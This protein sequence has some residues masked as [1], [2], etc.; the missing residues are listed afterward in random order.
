M[1]RLFRDVRKYNTPQTATLQNGLKVRVT[2]VSSVRHILLWR[3][4]DTPPSPREAHA[5]GKH[6]GFGAFYVKR[7]KT[8][9]HGEWLE[10]IE[11]QQPF[12]GG[13]A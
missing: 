9:A 11:N 3:T 13:P 2:I 7:G 5:I 4:P 1:R 8:T 6:A 10:L 12:I